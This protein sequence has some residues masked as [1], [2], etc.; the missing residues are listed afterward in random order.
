MMPPKK[1]PQNPH[2][3]TAKQS[4]VIEDVKVKIKKGKSP[5]VLQSVEKI[6]DV[7]NR[8]SANS[9][10]QKNMKNLNFREALVESLV[11]KKIVGAN[12]ATEG[13]LLD[14]LQAVTPQG[15][16]NFDARL[17]YVQEINKITG[18]YAPERRQTLNLNMDMSEEEL[19]K[20]IKELQE[21]LS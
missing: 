1:T 14:G 10:L 20:H 15:D 3:L 6:Y 12:S 18:V 13:V 17:K 5:A 11:E 7:K 2:G 4:L 8:A 19:D 9:V 16:V 21:Q